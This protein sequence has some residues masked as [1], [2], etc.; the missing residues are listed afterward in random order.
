MIT[1]MRTNQ[2][3]GNLIQPKL[4][5]H[6]SFSP[7]PPPHRTQ[8]PHPKVF[9]EGPDFIKKKLK[10]LIA[11]MDGEIESSETVRWE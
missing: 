7:L 3:H 11:E 2:Y 10:L 6:P 9:L 8:S 4:Y 5:V 1:R